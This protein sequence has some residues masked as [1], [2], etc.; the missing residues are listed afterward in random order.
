MPELVRFMRCLLTSYV[1]LYLVFAVVMV[2]GY[3]AFGPYV[4]SNLLDAM[5]DDAWAQAV[6]QNAARII[7]L[8]QPLEQE[9]HGGDE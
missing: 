3:M 5:P 1:F 4:E 2:C 6:E 8:L 7:K 9:F